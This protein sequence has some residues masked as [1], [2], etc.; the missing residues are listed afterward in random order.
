MEI[1]AKANEKK[2]VKPR[3]N[4]DVKR[5]DALRKKVKELVPPNVNKTGV[6]N[7]VTRDGLVVLGGSM[8]QSTES[9]KSGSLSR[10]RVINNL[11]NNTNL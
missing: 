3:N 2:L 5:L 7:V 4:T 8:S 6:K 10:S 11:S 9:N 1:D